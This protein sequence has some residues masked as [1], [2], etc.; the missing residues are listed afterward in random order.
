MINHLFA[1]Q[2]VADS[3]RYLAVDYDRE[4]FYVAQ[5]LYPT[6]AE[7]QIIPVNRPSTGN[8]K[9]LSAGAIA[10]IVVGVVAILALIGGLLFFFWRRKKN[11]KKKTKKSKASTNRSSSIGGTTIE[12]WAEGVT[13]QEHFEPKTAD[14]EME[15]QF[16]QEL[17]ATAT[18]RPHY[19]FHQRHELSAG[20]V[21]RTSQ[22]SGFSRGSGVSPMV[23][24]RASSQA[25]HRSMSSFGQPSPGIP[26]EISRPMSPQ[27]LSG[28]TSPTA[29]QSPP[30]VLSS[31]HFPPAFELHGDSRPQNRPLSVDRIESPE[32]IRPLLVN[33]GD[34]LFLSEDEVTPLREGNRISPFDE[35]GPRIGESP[36]QVR[37]LNV[38]RKDEPALP[39]GSVSP[40]RASSRLS[41]FEEQTD[42]IDLRHET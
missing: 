41:R 2:I 6:G 18:A 29:D 32:P 17:D 26:G 1:R 4:E 11:Q 28:M 35:E 9:G 23:E 27:E 20:S 37:P 24:N 8:S 15:D 22:Q 38:N 12:G 13:S 31:S 30:P 36:D 39:V 34:E 25:G 33:R 10:G 7:T 21:R 3:L 16:K 5:A 40:V 42:D 14:G 19:G